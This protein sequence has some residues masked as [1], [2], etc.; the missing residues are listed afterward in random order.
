MSNDVSM[1]SY[2]VRS[3]WHAKLS[4][5]QE[6][7]VRKAMN[8]QRNCGMDAQKLLAEAAAFSRAADADLTSTKGTEK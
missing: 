2:A 3:V 8:W 1:W 5:G 6:D 7:A 4:G